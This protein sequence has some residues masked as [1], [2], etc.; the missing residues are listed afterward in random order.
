MKAPILKTKELLLRVSSYAATIIRL[1]ALAS[2]IALFYYIV[3]DDV[4]ITEDNRKTA[5]I[6]VEEVERGCPL[7]FEAL[8]ESNQHVEILKAQVIDLEARVQTRPPLQS[9]ESV[10]ESP[11]GGR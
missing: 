4:L 6:C 8:S 9:F 10:F 5:A 2:L 7:V 3:S 1:A 11:D